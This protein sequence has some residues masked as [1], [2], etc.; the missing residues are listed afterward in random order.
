MTAIFIACWILGVRLR[1]A[2]RITIGAVVD[3]G[4]VTRYTLLRYRFSARVNS[5]RWHSE[6]RS[7]WDVITANEESTYVA[8]PRG[9]HADR[10]GAQY[11]PAIWHM[12]TRLWDERGAQEVVAERVWSLVGQ[13]KWMLENPPRATTLHS[14][15]DCS[16]APEYSWTTRLGEFV[17]Y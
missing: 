2:F 13:I 16:C 12:L 7:V 15:K 3:L 14:C 6:A 8:M 5:H 9:Q 1:A 10:R 4:K 17:A 11:A